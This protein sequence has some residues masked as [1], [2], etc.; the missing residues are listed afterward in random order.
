LVGTIANSHQSFGIFLD[1]SSNADL[2]LKPGEHYQGW[3]LRS[4]QGREATLEKDQ[5]TVILA[6]P[7]RSEVAS[8]RPNAGTLLPATSQSQPESSSR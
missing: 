1:Q 3:K 2:R 5:Q 7:L 6:L 8:P 4:V